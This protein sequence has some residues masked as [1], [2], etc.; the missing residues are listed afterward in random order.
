[1]F[2]GAAFFIAVLF[3]PK[4]FCGYNLGNTDLDYVGGDDVKNCDLNMRSPSTSGFLCFAGITAN[5]AAV[6]F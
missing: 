5:K 4:L 3:A 2:F 1:M 6:Q